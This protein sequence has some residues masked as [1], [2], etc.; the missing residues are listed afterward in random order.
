MNEAREPLPRVSPVLRPIVV[1]LGECLFDVV[2]DRAMLGGAPLNAAFQ[3]HQLAARSGGRGVVVTRVGNDPLGRRA[4]DELAVRGLATDWVQVD[5]QA[6]TGRALVQVVDGKTQ[7]AIVPDVAWDRLEFTE[8]LQALAAECHAV[9]FGTLG[10]RSTIARETIRR[11]LVAAPQAIRLFDVNFRSPFFNAEI[12]KSCCELA[13]VVKLNEDELPIVCELA[14]LGTHPATPDD[15][16][17]EMLAR[18][19]LSAMVLT[20]GAAGTVLYLPGRRIETSPV[21]YP[22]HPQAD[23]VG[24]GDACSAGLVMG[25]L[26]GWSPE[27][28][29]DLANRMGAYVASQPGATVTLPQEI[30]QLVAEPSSQV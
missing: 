1:G 24:A 27:Q 20:R 22:P 17:G 4:V 30:R 18:F 10:Q 5:P 19:P 29:V 3:A 16:A 12:V 13:T 15:R 2:E 26:R 14:G 9:F 28:T 23:A 21:S 6:E 11:F 25:M 7:F 8:G